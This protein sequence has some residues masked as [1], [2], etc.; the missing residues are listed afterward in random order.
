MKTISYRR[1]SSE[2]Q[3]ESGL[4]LEAQTEAIENYFGRAPDMDFVD[5]GIS[6][7]RADRP[8]LLTAI[9]ALK[10]G[11]TLIVAKRDRLSRDMFLSCWI[12]K[13]VKK[14]GA[15]IVSV[16]GEG[17]DGDDPTSVLMRRVVDAFAEYERGVIRQRTRAALARKRAKGQRTGNIPYGYDLGPD[18]VALVKNPREWAVLGKIQA[19]R[20]SGVSYQKIAKKLNLKGHRAKAGG[21]WYAAS[22]RSVLKTRAATA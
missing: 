10:R 15:T 5:E 7:S 20:E 11:D 22:V 8:G 21:E 3:A 18:G 13:E 4:G 12:E 6:G 2:E 17:T 16:A 19:M 1:V 14:K 9:D